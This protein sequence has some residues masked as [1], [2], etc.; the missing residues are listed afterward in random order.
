MTAADLDH[1]LHSYL[2]PRVCRG[3]RM[4]DLTKRNRERS[5]LTGAH[6][7]GQLDSLAPAS[8]IPRKVAFPHAPDQGRHHNCR[9][10]NDSGSVEIGDVPA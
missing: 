9:C 5:E 8:S 1:R 3:V 6:S 4:A 7:A 10:I 2:G